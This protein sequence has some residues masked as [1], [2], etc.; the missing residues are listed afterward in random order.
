M[1]NRNGLLVG[2]V[3]MLL[4]ILGLCGIQ[5]S[6]AAMSPNA[7]HIVDV[8]SYVN[9]GD[10]FAPSKLPFPKF[11]NQYNGTYFRYAD[12]DWGWQHTWSVPTNYVLE[13][14]TLSI[15]CFDIDTWA[16][17]DNILYGD[18]QLIGHQLGK[19][20]KWVRNT[21]DLMP[22]NSYLEDGEFN[23]WMDID[24]TGIGAATGVFTSTL[25]LKYRWDGNSPPIHTPAP[26]AALLGVI[27][28]GTVGW[29]RRRKTSLFR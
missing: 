24:P 16:G 1:K 22:L 17:E 25:N 10:W 3:I 12:Q 5:T 27:G 23:I 11:Q 28:I 7:M 29:L 21:F 15:R 26:G 13:S 2:T 19:D 14:A 8:A 6:T 4:W 20:N 9:T 18:G